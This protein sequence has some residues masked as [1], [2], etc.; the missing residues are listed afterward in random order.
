M[1]VLVPSGDLL[2]IQC[3]AVEDTA[4]CICCLFNF[5]SLFFFLFIILFL[6]HYSWL[7]IHYSL[8]F[9]SILIIF[10]LLATVL[11][12]SAIGFY[13]PTL[14][15]IAWLYCACSGVL[16]HCCFIG[17]LFRFIMLFYFSSFFLH[18]LFIILYFKSHYL[19]LFVALFL[20]FS[21]II[22][23]C[24]PRC[25][26]RAPS[27]SMQPSSRRVT[28]TCSGGHCYTGAETVGATATPPPLFGQNC[29]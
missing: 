26:I 8:F 15:P 5:Y 16:L 12:K 22:C 25:Y 20:T 19:L 21:I 9:T 4:V 28:C 2:R 10:L 6:I 27:S 13:V 1:H 29:S 17:P 18:T 7:I 11:C 24:S 23:Y 3:N 14:R